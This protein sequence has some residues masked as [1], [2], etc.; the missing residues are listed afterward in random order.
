MRKKIYA[1]IFPF[2]MIQNVH[3]D[4]ILQGMSVPMT[5]EYN[6]NFA[7]SSSNPQSAY[8]SIVNPKYQVSSGDG[9]NEIGADLAFYIARSS[10]QKVSVNREDPSLSMH[11]QT[12]SPLGVLNL[13]ASYVKTST[14][15]AELTNSGTVQADGSTHT[16]K[17]AASYNRLLS[18]KFNLALNGSYTK[19]D[20]SGG[21]LSAY[22]LP[23][24]STQLNYSYSELIQPFVQFSASDYQS[25]SQIN[26][27]VSN[28]SANSR[29]MSIVG[30]AK[31]QLSDRLNVNF[32]FGFN[33][34]HA[35]TNNAGTQGEL[36][37][38]YLYPLAILTAN[39]SRK[40]SASGL[41]GFVETDQLDAG[42]THELTSRSN[43]GYNLTMRKAHGI[44]QS[45][46]N[47][48]NVTYRYE[49]TPSWNTS[50]YAGVKSFENANSEHANARI[51]GITLNYADFNF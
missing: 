34:V 1:C 28:Q 21:S 10:N 30:G 42:V 36:G 6:S 27:Q 25:D 16:K 24:I 23:A 47:Q 15:I 45:T 37:V 43:L 4:V 9:V 50:I 31:W 51:L 14:R 32:N 20:Y 38:T 8:R 11:W 46:L 29:F 19:V 22:K 18:D 39:A 12:E 17:L 48:V 40:V 49:L 2:V 33:Q 41:G 3:A 5:L 26:N 44:N 7:L 35:T 13:N